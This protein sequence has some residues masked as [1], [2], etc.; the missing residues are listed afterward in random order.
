MYKRQFPLSPD[1]QGSADAQYR[2]AISSTLNG[3]AGATATG[4]SSTNG[5]LLSGSASVATLE[6]LLKIKGY[7]L[8]D[9]RAGIETEDKQWRVDVWGRNV[10]SKYYTNG[11]TRN[12]D[13]V[14]QFAGMPATYGVTVKYRM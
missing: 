4:R 6:N 2:F 1:W 8:V 14:T 11:N 3:F 7:V 13:F 5:Q 9:L 10:F 12:S